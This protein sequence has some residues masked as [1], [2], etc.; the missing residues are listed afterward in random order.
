MFFT[1]DKYHSQSWA[2]KR[3]Y[4]LFTLFSSTFWRYKEGKYLMDFLKILF[5]GQ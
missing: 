2:N 4:A 1:G 5:R 3:A